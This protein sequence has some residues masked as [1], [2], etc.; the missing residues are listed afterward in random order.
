MFGSYKIGCGNTSRPALGSFDG[1]KVLITGASGFVGRHLVQRCQKDG[2]EVT[3]LVRQANHMAAS[4]IKTH[5][6]AGVEQLGD[7]SAALRDQDVV[8]HC[9]AR[10]HVMKDKSGDPLAAFRAVNVAGTLDLARQAA[11]AGIARF[12]YL[13]SVKVL[14][15]ST[16]PG[17]PF[18]EEDPPCPQDAY[19]QSKCEA[20]TG[21]RQLALKTGMQVVVIRPPLVYGAGVGANFKAMMAAVR[22]G[23]PLPLGRVDNRRSLVAIENLVDFITVCMVHP[24]AADQTFLVSDGDDLS[25][26]QLLHHL[27]VSLGRPARL[28]PVPAWILRFAATLVGRSAV[29]ERLCGSLQ[30]DIGKARRLLAWTPPV[31]VR[32]GLGHAAQGGTA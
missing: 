27:G 28:L 31:A 7:L 16:A 17:R 8:V 4:G 1:M 9:A 12:I 21:L 11:A 30:A 23:W 24:A 14:G 25:T 13:S 5:V 29:A 22:R 6:I 3:A 10:V 15:E 26:T 19:A 20:E 32:E 2:L 18:T